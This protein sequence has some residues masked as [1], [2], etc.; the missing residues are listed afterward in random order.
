MNNSLIFKL[1]WLT[2]I[3]YIVSGTSL[4]L[5]ISK[6]GILGFLAAHSLLLLIFSIQKDKRLVLQYSFFVLFD[7]SVIHQW[8]FALN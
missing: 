3:L 6:L 1:K 7:S 8:F 5:E 4:V 2:T